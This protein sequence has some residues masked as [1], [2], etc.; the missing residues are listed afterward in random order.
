MRIIVCTCIF[1]FA[2]ESNQEKAVVP[3]NLTDFGITDSSNMQMSDGGVAT[4]SGDTQSD[5]L[6]PIDDLTSEGTASCKSPVVYEV[7]RPIFTDSTEAWGLNE[8]GVLGTRLTI[9][10]INGD[11]LPDFAARRAG[12]HFDQF[13]ETE[14][15]TRRFHWLMLNRGG[16]FEDV[17][18][19]SGWNAV[20][21]T[22]PITVG[23]PAEVVAF[24]DVDND[25]DL[26]AYTGVDVRQRLTLELGE[27]QPVA[28]EERSELLINDGTGH[29][30]LVAPEHPLRRLNR[31]DVPSGIS[32]VDMNL[33]GNLDAWITQGGLGAPMQ[34]RVFIGNGQGG[35]EDIT[36]ESGV[37]TESWIQAAT[38]NEGRGHSTA[39]SASACD[40]NNDGYPELIAG[41]YG[42]APN[43]LWRSASVDGAVN[44]VN[45]SV[46]S[47]YAYDDDQS[48]GDNQF[49]A[50]YCASNSDA[51]GCDSAQRPRINCGQTNWRHNTDREPFRLGGNTGTTVCADFDNDGWADL[52]TTEIK[53]WWAGSSSDASELLLNAQSSDVRFT[54]PGNAQTGLAIEHGGGSW[55]E[56]IITATWLDFD[57]DGRK[58]LYMG[59]TDYNGNRGRL[60]HNQSSPGNPQ[61][62][63][64][65]PN[66]GID[67]HRSHGVAV[68]DFD[69]DGDMDLIVG[70]SRNRCDASDPTNCYST[71]QVRLFENTLN[72]AGN[73]IQLKLEGGEG[74]NRS[75]IGAVVIVNTT[76]GKQRFEVNG[77]YGHYGAQDD[78]LVHI[79]IGPDCDATVEVSWP[80]EVRHKSR[81]RLPANHR[82]AITENQPPVIV[83]PS[84]PSEP[85]E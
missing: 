42:R 21:G 5:A 40:L 18:Q 6:L 80:N 34:D 11:G 27:D 33:D 61:F 17:T 13:T 68:A 55:D 72:D 69:G 9:G 73:W 85:S 66:L 23:R 83:S 19:S 45:E 51:E 41:S 62:V 48:W 10:D 58:D 56:G 59:G 47:G 38:M 37:T 25:G 20:R 1:L 54:R 74:T 52:V 36:S 63:E 35:F 43:H 14:D 57:N 82:F 77:G 81:Y 7:D 50:C 2:C 46:A 70:H 3:F 24:A 79:G 22:Y 65:Q 75:A 12:T 15:T 67:Q 30:T 64:V 28:I 32:F 8:A 60:Y 53:H 76:Q 84:E 31:Q 78:M 26:D 4:D 39:W 44:Y 16:S 49:A 29:F 71:R